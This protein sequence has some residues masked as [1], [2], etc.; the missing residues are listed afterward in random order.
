MFPFAIPISIF[1][2]DDWGYVS[3]AVVGSIQANLVAADKRHQSADAASRH[4]VRTA[5]RILGGLTGAAAQSNFATDT[6]RTHVLTVRGPRFLFYFL[7]CLRKNDET[8]L[9]LAEWSRLC[10]V[11]RSWS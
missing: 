7:S 1:S 6:Q 11:A 3:P 8:L 5:L 9:L 2:A 10:G 4:A